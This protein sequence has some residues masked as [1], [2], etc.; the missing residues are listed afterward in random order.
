MEDP[1]RAAPV[2]KVEVFVRHPFRT[3]SSTSSTYSHGH[4][5]AMGTSESW[6]NIETKTR[7]LGVP[8]EYE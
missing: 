5:K 7:S 2:V 4:L 1:V 6:E 3:Q 8:W